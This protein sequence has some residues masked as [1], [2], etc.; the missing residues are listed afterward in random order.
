MT[1]GTNQELYEAVRVIV[2]LLRDAGE[3][4]LAED[5]RS[6]LAISSLPGEILGE[7]RM[8]LQRLGS[9]PVYGK[10]EI[11]RRV[12]EGIDYVNRALGG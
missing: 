11:R 1:I 9:H 5:L 8:T 10:L 3:Q 6:A 12:D 4:A 2:D 7:I